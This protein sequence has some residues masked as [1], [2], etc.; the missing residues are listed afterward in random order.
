MHCCVRFS[1]NKKGIFCTLNLIRMVSSIVNLTLEFQTLL[2][3]TMEIFINYRN[4]AESSDT[5][6][7][8]KIIRGKESD[9]LPLPLKGTVL[10]I[11]PSKLEAF[12]PKKGDRVVLIREDRYTNQK[13]GIIGTIDSIDTRTSRKYSTISRLYYVLDDTG[14][15]YQVYSNNTNLQ[16]G[17][18]K[19]HEGPIPEK[20]INRWVA[21]PKST[22]FLALKVKRFTQMNVG[23][24]SNIGAVVGANNLQISLDSPS[25]IGVGERQKTTVTPF[26]KLKSYLLTPRMWRKPVNPEQNPMFAQNPFLKIGEYVVV[27]SGDAIF[28]AKAV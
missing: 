13:Q 20:D 9:W 2:E 24:K 28:T 1:G 4:A 25:I 14:K 7:P 5:T 17:V 15:M 11:D 8:R 22:G 10:L 26:S 27:K 3:D 19:K 18:S 16:P 21:K 12:Q 23:G 6:E